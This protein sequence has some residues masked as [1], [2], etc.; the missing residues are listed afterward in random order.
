MSK[1]ELAARVLGRS[2]LSRLR[3]NAAALRVLAYHRVVEGPWDDFLF[4][5]HIISATPEAFEAQMRFAKKN[6]DV[7][8]FRDLDACDREDKP[9][10]KKALIVTFDDGYRDNFTHAFPVLRELG[11]PATIFLTT[12][13]I[14]QSQLFWWDAIAYCFKKTSLAAILMPELGEA[15][16]PLATAQQRRQAVDAALNWA[17]NVPDAVRKGFVAHL[18]NVLKVQLPCDVAKGM[19][20]SWDEVRLM[21]QDGIEFGSHTVTHPILS[22]VDNAQLL[23][24]ACMSK[25]TIEREVGQPALSFAFPAGT[26]KRRSQA[27]HAII[28]EC[29][30]HFAVVYDQDVE[31]HPDRIAMPRI[32]VDRDHSLNLFRANLLFPSL[33]LRP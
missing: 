21:A 15:E 22:C 31:V 5:E 14:D 17:K 10:P 26:R 9:W 18:P 3:T 1:R 19:H 20:L 28:K 6:F 12:G 32:H 4:D 13:H 7:V 8:S 11:L 2:A 23:Y 29:G 33:M 16:M 24:E 25:S 27:A 30:Y